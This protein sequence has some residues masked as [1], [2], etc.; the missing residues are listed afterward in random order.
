[1][2]TLGG[3]IMIITCPECGKKF[4]DMAEA[5]PECGCPTSKITI[6]NELLI[7]NNPE[8]TPVVTKPILDNA[9]HHKQKRKKRKGCLTYF[10]YIITFLCFI[11]IISVIFGLDEDTDETSTT[12]TTESTEKMSKKEQFVSDLTSV[13]GVK[14]KAAKSAYSIIKN[15]L[16]YKNIEVYETNG[17]NTTFGIVADDDYLYIVV[18][19][20]LR[21]VWCGDFTLYEND[22]VV[23]T[24]K[25]MDNRVVGDNKSSYYVISQEIISSFLKAPSTADFCSQDET[26]MRRNGDYVVV[27][28]YVD[29]QN[30]FGAMIRSEFTVEFKVNDLNNFEYEILYV[31]IDGESSGEFKDLD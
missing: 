25:E 31:N 16:G 14:K 19:D 11:F 4:S 3:V 28:G 20:K 13:N 12:T 17:D 9:Q 10:L 2:K 18:N 22:E 21:R 29:S 7:K 8:P 26:S 15:D 6:N 5:C 27:S 23:M 30:S 1:M 24:K